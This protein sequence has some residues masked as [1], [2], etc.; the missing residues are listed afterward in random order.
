MTVAIRGLALNTGPI[1][2]LEGKGVV[3]MGVAD[4]EDD[5]FGITIEDGDSP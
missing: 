1:D 3:G 5:A 2:G 4:E